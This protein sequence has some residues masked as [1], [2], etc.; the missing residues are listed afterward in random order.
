M[1]P[2]ALPV[3]VV[4]FLCHIEPF[5]PFSWW[6]G[7]QRIAMDGLEFW[8]FF[9]EAESGYKTSDCANLFLLR[10]LF[11]IQNFA[12]PGILLEFVSWWIR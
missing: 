9:E 1:C 8:F 10:L 2:F 6:L 3:A 4:S 5:I 11:C 12:W 7:E